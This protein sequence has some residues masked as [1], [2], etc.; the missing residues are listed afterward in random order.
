MWGGGGRGGGGGGGKLA[1][2][3]PLNNTHSPSYCLFGISDSGSK[4]AMPKQCCPIQER[5]TEADMHY[6]LRDGTVQFFMF[7]YL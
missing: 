3:F 6:A 1:E 5:R 2:F 7:V 4:L